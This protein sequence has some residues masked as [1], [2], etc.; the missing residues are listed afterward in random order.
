MIH[1]VELLQYSDGC[2]RLT[3]QHTF[4][5]YILSTTVLVIYLTVS[6]Q[7]FKNNTDYKAIQLATK[8]PKNLL[9]SVQVFCLYV[10]V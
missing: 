1:N 3:Q 7:Y 6:V 8:Q 5:Y 4:I 2:G 10:F 9:R